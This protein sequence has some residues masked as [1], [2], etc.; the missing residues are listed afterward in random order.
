MMKENNDMIKIGILVD[1]HKIPLWANLM[2]NEITKLNFAEISVLLT[3]N[4]KEF[5]NKLEPN[6]IQKNFFYDLYLSYEK[7][8][9]TPKNNLCRKQFCEMFKNIKELKISPILKNSYHTLSNEDVKKIEEQKLD[10]II[11]LGFNRL[12]GKILTVPKFGVWSY[13]SSNDYS[14]EIKFNGFWEVF[15]NNPVCNVNLYLNNDEC[16]KDAII[17][18]SITSTD[19]LYISRNNIN[20]YWK[21]IELVLNKLHEIHRLGKTENFSLEKDEIVENMYEKNEPTFPNNKE[22]I[23]LMIKHWNRYLKIKKK[24]RNKIEQWGILFDF[25]ENIFESIDQCRKILPPKDRYYADPFILKK[26]NEYFVFIE[27]VI[28][29]EKKGHIS[30]FKID[31]NGNYTSPK[32]ILERNYHM[33]YPFVFEFENNYY[34]IPETSEN[35]SIDLYKCKKFPDEWEF[36]KN[37][38]KNICAV[39]STLLRKDNLWWLFTSIPFMESSS[40]DTLSIFYS[41]DL[42]GNEWILHPKNPVISDVRKA[43]SAGK[44][45]QINNDYV[46]PS[47]DCSIGYGRGITF[48]KIKNLD[49]LSY[50]DEKIGDVYPEQA[51]I[52]GI[53]TFAQ[54]EKLRIFDFKQLISQ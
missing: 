13:F 17:S 30:Y 38:M 54:C 12:Y 52:E 1:S 2:V 53:H 46:R 37:I 48:S 34:M 6:I 45:L 11:R 14:K 21:N 47:Q 40:N 20:K 15:R 32:K 19:Q 22:V 16:N 26:D 28:Y 51:N 10:V 8:R 29:K 4:S 25:N 35:K 50:D 27:E 41:D 18:Q 42:F 43:R 7:K 3:N 9:F 31:K 23:Q 24:L 49:E 5:Q 36:E 33:S 39:D 44:I